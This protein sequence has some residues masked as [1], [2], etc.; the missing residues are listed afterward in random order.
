MEDYKNP[1]TFLV[2]KDVSKI[3]RHMIAAQKMLLMNT[4]LIN[5]TSLSL[6]H[7]LLNSFNISRLHG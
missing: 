3:R 1:T 6:F 4:E 5:R 2:P 7:S